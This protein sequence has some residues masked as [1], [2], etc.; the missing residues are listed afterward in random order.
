M[1]KS[2]A[3]LSQPRLS[4]ELSINSVPMYLNR[5]QICRGRNGSTP[6]FVLVMVVVFVICLYRIISIP[7]Y[8]PRWSSLRLYSINSLKVGIPCGVTYL[9]L[10]TYLHQN[11]SLT[12][13]HTDA[14]HA[15][16]HWH[17]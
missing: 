8:L 17:E 1:A 14:A 10:K 4:G 7:F 5:R 2:F 3:L 13:V 15:H 12:L 16:Q 9:Y 11:T 6:K